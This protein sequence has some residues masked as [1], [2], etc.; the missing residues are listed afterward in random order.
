[1]Q[2]E[3]L[4]QLEKHLPEE[5]KNLCEGPITTA[6]LSAARRKMHTNKSPRPDGLTTEFLDRAQSRPSGTLQQ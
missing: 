4:K 5:R 1:M 2:S 3:L 6:E